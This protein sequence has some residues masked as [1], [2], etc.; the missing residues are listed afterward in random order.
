MKTLRIGSLFSGYGGLDEGIRAVLD[1]EVAWV[2]DIDKGACKVLA[3]RYPDV[4]N[5]GDMTAIDWTQVEPVDVICG[6]SPC[7]DVSHAGRRAGMTEGTRSNLWVAMREA[8][9]TIRPGLVVWENV[10]GAYSAEAD[11]E[12][13]NDPRLLAGTRRRDGEPVL[14]ALGR[15][16][17]DLDSLGYVGGWH[18]I[19]AADV[20]APHGRLRVFV[21]AVPAAHAEHDGS[22]AAAFCRG[23]RKSKDEGRLREPQGSSTDLRLLPTPAVN[24][25]QKRI[26]DRSEIEAETGCWLWTG[27][28]NQAA[29]PYG[30]VSINGVKVYAHRASHAAFVGPIPDGHEVD[31]LCQSSLCVNPEHL[32]A[33]SPKENRDRVTR[34]RTHCKRGHEFTEENTYW[35]RPG[36][37]ACR[38]C[39]AA[40]DLIQKARKKGLPEPE[41]PLLPTP[42]CNDMGASYTPDEWDAWT[43][44]MKAEHGNG[45]GHGKSLHIEAARLLPTP[46]ATDGTK[47][48]PNQRGSSG[49]LMLPSAVNLLPTPAV[50]DTQGGRKSRSGDRSNELLLNGIA[51][52]AR[53]G[54]YEPAIRR[55]ESLTRPAPEPTKPNGKGNPKL[56]DEFDEW[57]MGYP[58]GWITDVPGVTW[59]EALKACGNG[60]VPQQGAA[61]LR[62]L[63]GV[64]SERVAA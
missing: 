42:T 16:L 27:W 34:R 15:V 32:E 51:A 49:D 39:R 24:D 47:G 10:A 33:V 41:M 29:T 57:L 25:D 54:E 28:T 59:N 35:V 21:V 50:A 1:A 3:H 23:A 56:S 44:R 52:E 7:Q 12:L 63:L 48:G 17:G 38:A 45:N 13:V 6:G 9:A 36:A 26:I 5:L 22:L 55:W 46:R 18:G 11:S 61:A 60:V 30:R 14:R 2:S 37:R 4:P 31:H 8:I 53:W 58:A 64:I 43:D 62:F 19:R 20:G 40:Q